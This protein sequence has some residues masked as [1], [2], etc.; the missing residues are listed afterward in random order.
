MLGGIYSD[1]RCPVC[2]SN[3]KDD[4]RKGLCCPEHPECR[5]T[6]FKVK[7][8]GIYRRFR[9]YESAQRWLVGLRFQHDQ[10]SFDPRDY[11]TDNPLGFE[12][13]ALKFLEIKRNEVNSYRHI[14]N[15][16]RKA[17]AYWGNTNIKD[18]R[19]AELE[20]FL[21]AK[22]DRARAI[23][24][25]HKTGLPVSAKTRANIK[26]TL[27]HFWVWLR[28]RQVLRLDQ[29]PEFPDVGFELGWRKLVDKATQQK[30]TDEVYRL[31]KPVNIKI[32]IGIKWL[33]TYISI[34]PKELLNIKEDDFNLDLGVVIIR[35]P[36]EK[37]P[38]VVPLLDE[39][40]ELLKS[41]PRGLPH[42]YFFRHRSGLKGAKAGE[43]F[44]S[45]I[46]YKYWKKACD[47]LGIEGVDLYGGT[48][49]S[50]AT[51]LRMYR[52]PEQIKRATMH[53][54]NKAFDRYF[55]IELEDLREVYADTKMTPKRTTSKKGKVIDLKEK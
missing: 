21:G 14:A 16:M 4:G 28:K 32:W 50:S 43:P 46:L 31:A 38:K 29:I 52:T 10:G 48:K 9:D 5:A 44:G 39:D 35:Q 8:K 1:Q 13:L 41:F 30:I 18:I 22:T 6:S 42:L 11:R 49:H 34:R 20:D 19:Y 24:S 17:I 37:K 33:C 47:N 51:A 2:G 25:H 7:F 12:T 53:A 45:R 27:H 23:L 54:T 36:K 3:F 55:R 40:V 15:H 26:A